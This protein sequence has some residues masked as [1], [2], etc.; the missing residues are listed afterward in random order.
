[1]HHPVFTKFPPARIS[2]PVGYAADYLGNLTRPAHMQKAQPLAGGE[3]TP[4]MPAIDEEYFEWIDTLE[5]TL[6]AQ[7]SYTMLELGAGYGRWAARAYAAAKRRGC[8]KIHIGLIEAEPAHV[9]WIDEHMADNKIAASD[10]RVF[11]MALSTREEAGWFYVAMPPGY[12]SNSA[13]EWYG[14][15]L[16][17]DPHEV[18]CQ[19]EFGAEPGNSKLAELENLIAPELRKY[20]LR[21]TFALLPGGWMAMRVKQAPL[22]S[23]L[24]NY[25]FIDFVDADIQGEEIHAFPEAIDELTKRAAYVHVGTHSDQCEQRLREVFTAAGWKPIWDFSCLKT[26]ITPYGE[27]YFNDGV[28]TWTNPRLTK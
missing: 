21:Q 1:M 24:R 17:N 3:Q 6:H 27:V 8:A 19:W 14:Q 2:V 9:A 12:A 26:H 7:S 11:D 18:L 25:E 28:Q 22:S 16:T 23:I 20:Y 5:S 13:K 4:V 15:A 10:F